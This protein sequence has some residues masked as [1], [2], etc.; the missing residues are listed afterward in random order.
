MVVDEG[1]IALLRYL[2]R[3]SAIAT[4]IGLFS[5]DY[6]PTVATVL[7]D[8]TEPSFAGYSQIDADGVTWPDPTINGSDQGESDGPTLTWTC[9]ADPGSPVDVHGIFVQINDETGTHRLFFAFRFAAP[10]T[11]AANGDEVNKSLNWFGQNLP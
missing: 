4:K 1:L 7:G 8:L 10:V 3:S 2:L 11:I 9:T 5:N 6:T